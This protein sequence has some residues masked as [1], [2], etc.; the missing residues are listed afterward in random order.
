MPDVSGKYYLSDYIAELQARG[1]NGFSAA[2]LTT[3]VNRGYFHVAR[4]AR[5]LW[6]QTTDT[7]TLAPGAAYVDL[8]PTVA[9]ELPNFRSLDKLY[10]TTTNYRRKLNPMKDDDFFLKWLGEDLTLTSNQAEPSWYYIWQGKLYILPPPNA[11]RTFLAHYHQRVSAL[12]NPTDQ[13]ITPQHL[14]EAILDAALIRAHSR[15][16]EPQLATMKRSDLEEVFD[17]MRDD[18]EEQM[19]EVQWR[20][21]PDN[22]WL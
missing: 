13:P 1:F 12:V 7:F 4:K 18:E 8:W 11:S 17:D 21:E 5:W 14:D 15:A 3:Y 22:T 9:G 16:Q 2:D 10:I 20:V 6:E 19:D